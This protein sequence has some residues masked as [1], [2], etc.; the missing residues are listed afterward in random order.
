MRSILL[1]ASAFALASC[2]GAEKWIN[3]S[4]EDVQ[5]EG[6][7]YRVMWVRNGANIDTRVFRNEALVIMPDALI[8]K[9]RSLEAATQAATRL[10]GAPPTQTGETKDGDLWSASFVCKS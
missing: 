8:E 5:I 6:V 7:P 1:I 4:P 10:C 2:A 3:A 9:R